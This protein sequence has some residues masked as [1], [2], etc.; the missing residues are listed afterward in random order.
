MPRQARLDAPGTLHH[1]IIRGIE[2]KE[3]VKD[4]HDRQN[5]VYRMVTIDLETGTL[6]YAWT[7]MTNSFKSVKSKYS[8]ESCKT[9]PLLF[10]FL[11]PLYAL[12]I[13]P[14]SSLVRL[15]QYH[16]LTFCPILICYPYRQLN[17]MLL[18]LSSYLLLLTL[19]PF[20]SFQQLISSSSRAPNH[21][22]LS[23]LNLYQGQPLGVHQF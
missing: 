23:V 13:Y 22:R 1:V 6:I 3:I 12:A 14:F 5:F 7:L 18:F 16:H 17:A 10:L 20:S 19:L 2:R 21:D 4:D 9:G 8:G 15:S 11:L